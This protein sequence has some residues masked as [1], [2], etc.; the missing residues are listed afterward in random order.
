MVPASVLRSWRKSARFEI[1]EAYDALRRYI[2]ISAYSTIAQLVKF[3]IILCYGHFNI[4]N[5]ICLTLVLV[6][7]LLEGFAASFEV[8]VLFRI[9]TRDATDLCG[10]DHREKDL[11]AFLDSS[12]TSYK[13]TFA[14]HVLMRRKLSRVVTKLAIAWLNPVNPPQVGIGW[15]VSETCNC[16]KTSDDSWSTFEIRG[17]DFHLHAGFVPDRPDGLL[18]YERDQGVVIRDFVVGAIENSA[19]V[20]AIETS[21]FAVMFNRVNIIAQNVLHIHLATWEMEPPVPQQRDERERMAFAILRLFVNFVE[22]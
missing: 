12:L 9:G 20:L 10:F 19:S 4:N 6:R 8:F 15:I 3:N 7:Y 11:I 21:R 17:L 22:R 18:Y 16:T 13:E 2:L 5:S 1:L 14:S